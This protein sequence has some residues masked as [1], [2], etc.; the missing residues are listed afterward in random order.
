MHGG[1]ERDYFG[2]AKSVGGSLIPGR[3]FLDRTKNPKV[4]GVLIENTSGISSVNTDFPLDSAVGRLIRE[5][6]MRCVPFTSSFTFRMVCP[7]GTK[8]DCPVP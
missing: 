7:G 3:L 6:I 5:R 2:D 8:F 1:A 4:V